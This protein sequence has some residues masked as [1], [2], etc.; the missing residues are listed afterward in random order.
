DARIAAAAPG[1]SAG[2]AVG[3]AG[4]RGPGIARPAARRVSSSVKIRSAK[5]SIHEREHSGSKSGVRRGTSKSRSLYAAGIEAD[6]S[7]HHRSGRSAV[8]RLPENFG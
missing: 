6:H 2:P 3:F 8:H 4:A 1:A 5:E 7:V